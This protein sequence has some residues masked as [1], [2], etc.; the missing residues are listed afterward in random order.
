MGKP[1]DQIAAKGF[2]SPKGP[3]QVAF[4]RVS[5]KCNSQIVWNCLTY[6]KKLNLAFLYVSEK[7]GAVHPF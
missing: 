1:V 4:W 6:T 3:R 5:N 2:R 7:V